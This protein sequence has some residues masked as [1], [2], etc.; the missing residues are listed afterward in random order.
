MQS[1]EHL[2]GMRLPP[3]RM[4][5]TSGGEIDLPRL[6]EDRIVV[7][8]YPGDDVPAR[9]PQP[10]SCEVQRASFRE[11]AL[12]FAAQGTK[13]TGLSSERHQ[14]QLAAAAAERLPFP[15]LSDRECRLAE[16]LELPT[17]LD[18]GVRRYRRL[19]L[20]CERGQIAAVLYPVP[21]RRSAIQALTWLEAGERR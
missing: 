14:D 8:L 7:Y 9:A 17:F 2:V 16:A 21:P 12:D 19:T 1:M 18:L 15:L 4:P 3:L 20:I 11:Y 6:S 10:T 13:I 5:S